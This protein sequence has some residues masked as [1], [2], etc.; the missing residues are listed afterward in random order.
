[1]GWIKRLKQET[2]FGDIK[3]IKA[4][5]AEEN[6]IISRMWEKSKTGAEEEISAET[7]CE[8]GASKAESL[9]R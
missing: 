3:V 1:L 6:S 4:A 5:E 9:C 8:D 2:N 7:S